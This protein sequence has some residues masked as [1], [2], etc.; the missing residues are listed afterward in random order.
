[1]PTPDCI[2]CYYSCVYLKNP[3]ERKFIRT[4]KPFTTQRQNAGLLCWFN[5][6]P[7]T[8]TVGSLVRERFTCAELRDEANANG[9]ELYCGPAGRNFEYSDNFLEL[10]RNRLAALAKQK[11]KKKAK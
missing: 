7:L 11:K 9:S 10:K 8:G 2:N 4:N 5:M 3:D 6:V 1:M